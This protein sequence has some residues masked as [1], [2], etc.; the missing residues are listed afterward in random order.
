MI[1][2]EGSSVHKSAWI[3]KLVLCIYFSDR[4]QH[5]IDVE[6]TYCRHIFTLLWILNLMSHKSFLFS[7]ISRNSSTLTLVPIRNII[8]WK[9]SV[10][11]LLISSTHIRCALLRKQ[12]SGR[13]LEAWSTTWGKWH[14]FVE[15]NLF[16]ICGMV[17]SV[18]LIEYAVDITP[19]QMHGSYFTFASSIHCCS[20]VE[21]KKNCATFS[22]WHFQ[23]H[24]L[25]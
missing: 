21:A 1:V 19:M 3:S 6:W 9:T 16:F 22:R 13:N 5:S 14:N 18:T 7:V 23:M 15:C 17:Q 25:E 11:S 10:L 2:N 4:F 8:L 20:Q 12:P 24:F